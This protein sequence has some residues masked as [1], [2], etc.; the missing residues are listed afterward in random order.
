MPGN[1]DAVMVQELRELRG[2]VRAVFFLAAEYLTKIDFALAKVEPAPALTP[3][4]AAPRELRAFGLKYL[5]QT[6]SKTLRQDI[7]EARGAQSA[8]VLATKL[9]GDGQATPRGP[10]A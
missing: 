4:N 2:E 10:G 1:T 9:D 5:R 3:A 6:S 8:C 7:V